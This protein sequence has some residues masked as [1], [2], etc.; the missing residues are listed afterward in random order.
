[1]QTNNK[2]IPETPIE[3]KSPFVS[4]ESALELLN[5]PNNLIPLKGKD[6]AG[7]NAETTQYQHN[8]R[9]MVRRSIAS[10]DSKDFAMREEKKSRAKFG[11]F[12][13]NCDEV[14]ISFLSRSISSIVSSQLNRNL[15]IAFEC[16][17]THKTPVQSSSVVHL[18]LYPRLT[19]V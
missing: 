19:M 14:S 1:M 6:K 17:T 5:T 12:A 3:C 8:V 15:D 10:L 13:H 9:Q 18:P 4:S 2:L 16:E 7:E 11:G